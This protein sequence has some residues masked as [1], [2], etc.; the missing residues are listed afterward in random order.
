MVLPL[1]ITASLSKCVALP[2]RSGVRIARFNIR[3][4]IVL[5]VK[6]SRTVRVGA[7]QD[8]IEAKYKQCE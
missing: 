6:V 4:K 5:N 8:P 7:D 2:E 3:V 1:A